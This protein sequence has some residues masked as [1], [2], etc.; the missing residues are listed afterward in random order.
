MTLGQLRTAKHLLN[1]A[2]LSREIGEDSRYLSYALA[3]RRAFTPEHERRLDE[4]LASANLA[5]R[6]ST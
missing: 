6:R 3:K 4:A 2:R 1:L 5:V